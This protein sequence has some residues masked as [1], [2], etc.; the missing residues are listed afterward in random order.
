[1]RRSYAPA[2]SELSVDETGELKHLERCL[3]KEDLVFVRTLVLEK[4]LVESQSAAVLSSAI[5]DSATDLSDYFSANYDFPSYPQTDRELLGMI[6]PCVFTC[7][8]MTLL[9]FRSF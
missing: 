9:A 1:M 8:L 2:T 5:I 3:P 6:F 7:L 4:L